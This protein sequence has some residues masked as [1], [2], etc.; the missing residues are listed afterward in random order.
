MSGY[1]A[2]QCLSP[3]Y[4][5]FEQLYVI[6]GSKLEQAFGAHEIT[7]HQEAIRTTIERRRSW[8]MLIGNSQ[9]LLR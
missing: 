7:P 4:T 8:R 1:P 6:E 2:L 9:W 3:L 5:R